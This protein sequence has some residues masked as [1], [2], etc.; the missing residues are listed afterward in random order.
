M[1][2]EDRLRWSVE[3]SKLG[4][5]GGRRHARTG[6]PTL[7]GPVVHTLR[8]CYSFWASTVETYYCRELKLE[9]PFRYRG[10]GTC[11]RFHGAT[12][13]VPAVAGERGLVL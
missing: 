11:V 3:N 4:I 1:K 8:H 10:R 5:C 13:G 2:P 12:P 7:L 6:L 9:D